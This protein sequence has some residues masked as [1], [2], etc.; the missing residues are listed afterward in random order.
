MPAKSEPFPW[1]NALYALF[2]CRFELLWPLVTLEAWLFIAR[3]RLMRARARYMYV[4]WRLRR[5]QR[6]LKE[7]H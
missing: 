4:V 1:S 2:L 6:A 3:V 5:A 7:L